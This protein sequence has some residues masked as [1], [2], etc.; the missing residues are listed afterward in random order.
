M[1]EISGLGTIDGATF[2][3][4]KSLKVFLSVGRSFVSICKEFDEWEKSVKIWR[5]SWSR[6]VMV[7]G[8]QGSVNLRECSPWF[9]NAD[10]PDFSAKELERSSFFASI[11]NKWWDGLVQCATVQICNKS[12]KFANIEFFSARVSQ[13]HRQEAQQHRKR[14]FWQV[15]RFLTDFEKLQ[16]FSNGDC[17]GLSDDGGVSLGNAEPW[18]TF[19]F[20]QIHFV[21]FLSSGSSLRGVFFI[22][23]QLVISYLCFF[24]QRAH[25]F[26][27][28]FQAW[29]AE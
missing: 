2:V 22:T 17:W 28:G 5:S 26:F 3:T 9:L 25:I 6:V 23:K 15:S 13:T 4:C 27:S 7:P 18:L 14:R 19:N 1:F 12:R 20:P 8:W 10:P 16:E 24:I 29:M 21:C 11:R